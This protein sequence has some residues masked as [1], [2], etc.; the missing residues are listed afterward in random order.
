MTSDT[1]AIREGKAAAR[2]GNSIHT[3]PYRRH[4]HNHTRNDYKS[5]SAYGRYIELANAWDSGWV[6]I[7]PHKR[8]TQ[9]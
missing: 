2:L 5:D 9:Q 7:P 3:N 1:G 6:S 4:L 8:G